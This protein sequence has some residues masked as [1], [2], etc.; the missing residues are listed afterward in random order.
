MSMCHLRGRMFL[1]FWEV[2]NMW[3]GGNVERPTERMLY[4]RLVRVHRNKFP[5]K[6]DWQMRWGKQGPP[7]DAHI[8]IQGVLINEHPTASLRVSISASANHA[9]VRLG[10]SFL[11]QA[12]CVVD[13]ARVSTIYLPTI[14]H[15]CFRSNIQH[16]IFP[17]ELHWSAWGCPSPG[18]SHKP[19]ILTNCLALRLGAL[20]EARKT[21]AVDMQGLLLY[22]FLESCI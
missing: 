3:R 20:K 16:L 5:M 13:L 15:F 19:N 4:R 9:I 6:C 1:S 2:E 12:R 17:R 21:F 18:Q 7:W 10:Q 22:T 11:K 8:V 14:S